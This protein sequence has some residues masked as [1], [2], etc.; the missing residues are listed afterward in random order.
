MRDVG[1]GVDVQKFKRPGNYLFDAN[2]ILPPASSHYI[3][4]PALDEHIRLR[5]RQYTHDTLNIAGQ[6]RRWRDSGGGSGVIKADVVG[7]SWILADNEQSRSFTEYFHRL[8]NTASVRLNSHKIE[9]GDTIILVDQNPA[10]LVVAI[11]QI[12]R[13]LRS[14]KYK[15]ELRAGAEFGVTDVAGGPVFRT[16]ARLETVSMPGVLCATREFRDEVNSID[17]RIGFDPGRSLNSL[18]NLEWRGQAVNIRKSEG[19]PD[20]FKEIFALKLE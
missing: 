19:D 1:T 6:G 10:N 20:L 13:D 14:G 16:A 4:H 8:V 17:G 11:R 12:A 18:A 5:A 3:I 7:Y 2:G 15:A 9:G